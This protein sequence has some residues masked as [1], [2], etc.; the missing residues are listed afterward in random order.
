MINILL[1]EDQSMVRQGLKMMIETDPEM[2]VLKEAQNG[3]EAVAICESHAVDLVIL[4]IRMPVMDGLEAAREIHRRWPDQ[5]MLIL[6]TFN[7]DDYALE[8]LKCGASGYM[9]KDAD[10]EE[11]IR[12]IRSCLSGGLTLQDHVAAKVM[13]R[14]LNQVHEKQE[15]DPSLTPREIAVIKLIGNGKNN[16]EIANELCLSVGTVKNHISVILDKL[17]LRDRTQ[18]A[19]Y[20]I[21]HHLV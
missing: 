11:L 21:R 14:L 4:D 20:A 13:P 8:A 2:R 7:D 12:A 18:I 17:T 6:T 19:I 16:Q 5:K 3:K 9:L 1:A 10:A 15:L